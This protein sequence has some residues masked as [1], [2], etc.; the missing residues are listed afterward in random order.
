MTLERTGTGI[1]GTVV[2]FAGASQNVSFLNNIMSGPKAA[3][4]SY[5]IYSTGKKDSSLNISNNFIHDGTY[6]I[7]L[8]ATAANMSNDVVIANNTIDSIL[9]AGIYAT[10]QR[11][12]NISQNTITHI[13]NTGATYGMYI[14]YCDSGMQ[15]LRNKIDVPNN[16]FGLYCLNNIASRGNRALIANNFV[17]AG[18]TGT[19]G[20]ALYITNN[21]YINVYFNNLLEISAATTAYGIYDASTAANYDSI[22]LVDNNAVNSGG[23]YAIY[24]RRATSLSASNYNNFYTSGSN[25]GRWVNT[26]TA[27]L[28]AWQTASGMDANSLSVDPLYYSNDDLHD[29]ATQ[30]RHA[31]LPL[32]GVTV[33]YDGQIR[34][35]LTPDIGADEVIPIADDVEPYSIL[36][37]VKNSCG[38]ST[39]AI[40]FVIANAGGASQINV[41][42]TVIISGSATA[43]YNDTIKTTL[44]SGAYDTITLK[45]TLNTFAGGTY[46]FKIYTNLFDDS[47]RAN[48]TITS[49]ISI[50][51][52]A[53]AP[54]VY[55]GS[56]CNSGSV[57]LAATP[58][59][60]L[61]QI[62]WYSA[63][64]GGT[65][66]HTGDTFSTPVISTTT[67]YYA[68]AGATC[69]SARVPVTAYIGAAGAYYTKDKL[70]SGQ[71]N[72]GTV[73]SPD[74]ICVGNEAV[75]DVTTIFQDSSYGKTW[76]ISNL[77]FL[78]IGGNKNTDTSFTYPATSNDAVFTFTP[79][80][81]AGDSTFVLSLKVK[82]LIHGCDTI[83]T[84]YIYVNPLP[85]ANFGVQ[86]GCVNTALNFYDS[87]KTGKATVAYFWN[88]GDT[89]T[90]TLQN[91]SNSYK[92]PGTYTVK[93]VINLSSG[94]SDSITKQVT[95]YPLPVVGFTSKALCGSQVAFTNSSSVSGGNIAAQTWYFG[96]GHTDTAANPT[97]TYSATGT[98]TVKLVA[99]SSKGC[100]DSA[101]DQVKVNS[102]LKAGFSATE[103]CFGDSSRFTDTT[104]STSK[105]TAW[106]W[107]FGDGDSSS[108][109]NPV[110][111]YTASGVYRAKLEV[112]S[113]A[114]CTDTTSA[115]VRVD[116]SPTAA[117]GVTSSAC[118]GS[119]V[120]F[121]DSSI[122]HGATVSYH[123][124]FGDKNVSTSQNPT[125][126]YKN[127]GTYTVKLRVQVGS[128]CSDSVSK[129]ITINPLPAPK[130]SYGA[131]CGL[132]VGFIDS[133]TIS[134]GSIASQSWSFGDKGVATSITPTH[135][136]TS[137]S[138][139]IV[140]LL[141]TSGKGCSDSVSQSI[142]VAKPLQAGFSAN[143]VCLGNATGFTDT[144]VSID[145]N[146][147]YHWNFGDGDSSASKSPSHIFITAGSHHV[148]L[149][150]TNSTSCTDTVSANIIVDANPTAAFGA[151]KTACQG[152][153]VNFADSSILNGAKVTYLWAF[154]NGDTS[155]KQNPTYTYTNAGNYRVRLTVSTIGKCFDSISKTIVIAPAPTAAFGVGNICLNSPVQFTD[156]STIA[157][158]AIST[159]AWNFGNGD[160]SSA[161][162]PTSTFTTAN[163]YSVFLAVT[164]KAGCT[165]TFTK[166]ITVNALPLATFKDTATNKTVKFYPTDTTYS[167]YS[168]TFGDKAV[169]T[170]KKPIHTYA[171]YGTYKVKLDVTD[172]NG[173]SSTDSLNVIVSKTGIGPDNATQIS[174]N[175]SPNPFNHIV[176]IDYNLPA[177][178]M[179]SASIYDMTGREIAHLGDGMQNEGNHRYVFDADQYQAGAGVYFLRMTID[180]NTI[181]EKIV[182]VR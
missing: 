6:G 144:T 108:V 159:Y 162:N 111:L 23:S 88:F 166:L 99:V 62:N 12:I 77:T 132:E 168:W 134:S 151:P 121:Y 72:A 102:A 68:Q 16:N 175:I 26:V 61:D 109:Q 49:S 69:L 98:Y 177:A 7:Y 41:P 85:K 28:K 60:P 40:S 48:D 79:K 127:A 95:I 112:T 119:T 157:S 81:N 128:S 29:K 150:V 38:D 25:L 129:Q 1:Y 82:D 14:G 50:V 84:R 19:A 173:C 57:K 123:W 46:N 96:D 152:S 147:T 89:V 140:K 54:T 172:K 125:N 55:S 93:L 78:S 65:S 120:S 160:T 124:D 35:A 118:Q 33:D 130:F 169:A 139:Y 5:I 90:S 138:N 113:A 74:A 70:F 36:S 180:G 11:A 135:T 75:Y 117:F 9:T 133:S 158:G 104:I 106:L 67:V 148:K 154:G 170:V 71:F 165:G 131:V 42:Y 21:K 110:H 167:T 142:A 56:N 141:V 31:G 182:R 91:P 45:T 171:S 13:V 136:Y 76:S 66:L 34:N 86:N 51:R 80:S 37:P 137:A 39:T 63:A 179:V 143:E 4:N 20:E 156:S 116:A 155:S 105:I 8:T 161:K 43:T 100:A 163:S 107:H 92:H 181:N 97:H 146:L 73:S 30:I 27:S 58:Q 44:A 126:T 115:I 17:T 22:R 149:T 103:V 64:T 83:I 15:I 176:N 47:N 101:S 153:A 59:N 164:S 94:C 52:R 114:G 122:T 10:Y 178:G 3:T 53:L 87:S 2:T 145:K 174:L 24:M 18:R 32:A